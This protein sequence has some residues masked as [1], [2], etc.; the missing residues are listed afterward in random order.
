MSRHESL[1]YYLP[2]DAG[3]D[4]P[5]EVD[6][7]TDNGKAP[8]AP[9]NVRLSISGERA[10]ITFNAT[11][12]SDVVGYRLYRSVNGAGFQNQGQVVLTG[13][14][15]SFSAYATLSGNFAFYV[16]A[17]DVA[18][19]ESAPSAIVSSAGVTPPQTED[20]E[21]IEVP[22]TVVT[23]GEAVNDNAPTAVPGTPGQVGVSALS[24]GLRIQWSSNPEADKVQSYAVYYSET[25]SGA[26]TKIG[27]TSGTS[28]DYGVPSST[29]GWFKVSAINSVGESDASV[30]VHYQP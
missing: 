2:E 19:R 9:G 27:T 22:G 6:P 30:A 3:A 15:R 5:T 4:L 1:A 13:E 28:M 21:P 14:S 7:R 18:G 20:K 8:D 29:S 25:G 26:Y 24:Q 16:T 12:E 11:P 23:P 17:V 10:T